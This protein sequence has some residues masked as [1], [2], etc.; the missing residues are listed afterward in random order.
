MEEVHYYQK[1]FWYEKDKLERYC[2]F[3]NNRSDDSFLKVLTD[4]FSCF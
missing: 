4:F 3:V 1:T 2:R